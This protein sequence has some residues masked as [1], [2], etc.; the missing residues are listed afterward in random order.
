MEKLTPPKL[1]TGTKIKSVISLVVLGVGAYQLLL[2]KT[3][4][5][6]VIGVVCMIYH[7]LMLLDVRNDLIEDKL[8]LL[9]LDPSEV[10]DESNGQ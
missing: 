6:G 10:K 8:K 2:G 3:A 7:Y 4:L 9:F 5:A 1:R